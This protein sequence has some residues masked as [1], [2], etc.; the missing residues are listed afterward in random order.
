[1]RVPEPV[2][3]PHR[4]SSGIVRLKTGVLGMEVRNDTGDASTP[5]AGW[6]TLS[7]FILTVLGFSF[8]FFMALPFAS[9][10]ESYGWLARVHNHGF[11]SAFSVGLASTYRPLHQVAAW[12]GFMI[13]NPGIFPTSVL[14]QALLQGFV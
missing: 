5:A 11:T 4:T 6:Q 7:Y 13:L 10:R 2:R 1:M 8:W 9:H 14:R 12:L 3:M